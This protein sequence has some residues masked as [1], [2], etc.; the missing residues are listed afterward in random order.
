[1][2]S[3]M[4]GETDAAAQS[5]AADIPADENRRGIETRVCE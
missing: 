5:T 1:M 3:D 2:A 4:P